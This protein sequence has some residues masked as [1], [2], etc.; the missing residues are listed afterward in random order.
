MFVD[1]NLENTEQTNKDEKLR[2]IS[3]IKGKITGNYKIIQKIVSFAPIL[4]GS[5]LRELLTKNI[6]RM[7]LVGYM[8]V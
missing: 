3:I 6:F 8:M 7:F 2:A 1:R 4:D 5:L